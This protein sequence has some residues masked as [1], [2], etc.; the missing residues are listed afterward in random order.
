MFFSILWLPRV[1][2]SGQYYA[3]NETARIVDEQQSWPATGM[4]PW[5]GSS[6]GFLKHPI[7][8]SI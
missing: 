7:D 4:G 3:S 1:V 2:P 8:C 6:I 5:F